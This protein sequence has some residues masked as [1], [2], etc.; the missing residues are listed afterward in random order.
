M[1]KRIDEHILIN[2]IWLKTCPTTLAE[3]VFDKHGVPISSVID[4]INSALQNEIQ[5]REEQFAALDRKLDAYKLQLNTDYTSVES[6]P[7]PG[8]SKFLYLIPKDGDKGNS[9]TEYVWVEKDNTYESIGSTEVNLEAYLLREEAENIFL[10]KTSASQLYREKISYAN[11]L[12]ATNADGNQ[13]SVTY[14]TGTTGN[15]IVQRDLNGQILVP[16]TPNSTSAATS[17]SYVDSINTSLKSDISSVNASIAS[18]NSSITS[19]KDDLAKINVSG[20][21]DKTGGDITGQLALKHSYTPHLRIYNTSYSASVYAS[22]WLDTSGNLW[23]HPNSS[24]VAGLKLD[25][26]GN[27]TFEK[28]VSIPETLTAGYVN[29]EVAAFD[30]WVT[31]GN[32]LSVSKDIDCGGYIRENGA[33]VWSEL[34]RPKA[35]QMP[36][37]TAPAVITQQNDT[38]VR[39]KLHTVSS[40]TTNKIGG[41]YYWFRMW[42]SGYQEMEGVINISPSND[43]TYVFNIPTATSGLGINPFYS[44]NYMTIQLTAIGWYNSQY[45]CQIGVTEKTTT[46]FTFRVSGSTIEQVYF[47]VSGIATRTSFND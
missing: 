46:S 21:L 9:Y 18:I 41:G 33:R 11:S 36:T 4:S 29:A 24:T 8:D 22:I 14:G 43:G 25:K 19:I 17:K 28:N 6:L 5:A 27:A 42:S 2:G 13:L 20:K 32:N 16:I 47:R 15:Y 23:I 3:L 40:N 38:V 37:S 1:A 39:Y 26:S 7:Y 10:S 34:N 31:V 35:T 12:Y 30:S 45:A 44:T